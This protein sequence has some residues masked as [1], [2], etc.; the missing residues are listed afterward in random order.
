MPPEVDAQAYRTFRFEAGR[1]P[2]AANDEAVGPQKAP[3]PGWVAGCQLSDKNEPIANVANVMVA[4]RAVPEI[5]GCFVLDEM[6]Q[7]IMLAQPVPGGPDERLGRQFKERPVRDTDVTALQEYLQLAGITRLSKDTTYQ[8]VELHATGQCHHP[9]RDYLEELVWDGVPRARMWLID[10]LGAEPAA[11]TGA[12]GEMFLVAMVTRIFEPGCK[13]DYMLVLEGPQGRN[14]SSACRVLGGQWFSDNLPDINSGKDVSLHLRGKWLVEIS[15]LSATS[16]A[17]ANALKSFVSRQ[18]EEYRPPYG[19][20]VV[21]QPRMCV[22]IGTTNMPSYLRDETGARRF[23]P[24]RTGRIDL[25][26][27]ARDRDQ[28]FA[29]AVNMYRD[30][31]RSWP[32]A[33]F[34]AEFIKPQQE[35]RFEVD[36]WEEP[37]V[38][39][40]TGRDDVTLSEVASGALFMD[41]SK[42]NRM[43]QLRVKAILVRL[44]WESSGKVK[45][46]RRPFV[47]RAAED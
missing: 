36:A 29:E 40:L 39:W 41:I 28:L 43:E 31:A 23:W 38:K 20:C 8:A 34:E 3:P 22:F 9:V 47:R 16:K 37:I 42:F 14:K 13:M 18:D 12:V 25:D 26:A 19:R 30:G 32:D 6:R 17:D 46:G 45:N 33:D 44:G 24:V 15:E 35:A 21:V 4:L 1:P 7:Q 27:L 10:Y 2:P 5:G 11:Y